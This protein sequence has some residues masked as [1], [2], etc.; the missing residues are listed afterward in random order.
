MLGV[1]T[2]VEVIGDSGVDMLNRIEGAMVYALVKSG[3]LVDAIQAG[4]KRRQ[5]A[6]LQVG[7]AAFIQVQ[8]QQGDVKAA[9]DL[10]FRAWVE[11]VAA[12]KEERELEAT[13]KE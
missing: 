2:T 5:R 4:Q 3:K 10:T 12:L 7:A 1:E 6:L 8:A 11:A 13:M 9:L